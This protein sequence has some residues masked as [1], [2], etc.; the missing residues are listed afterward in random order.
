[1]VLFYV[2]H[3]NVK[4]FFKTNFLIVACNTENEPLLNFVELYLNGNKCISWVLENWM[5]LLEKKVKILEM[6]RN[7]AMV[8]LK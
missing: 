7:F 8:D 4:Y 5:L 6:A 2:I 3:L 1:M